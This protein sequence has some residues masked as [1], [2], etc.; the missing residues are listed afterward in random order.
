MPICLH[1]ARDTQWVLNIMD[2]REEPFRIPTEK[3]RQDSSLCSLSRIL[4]IGFQGARWL[5]E[6]SHPHP[7]PRCLAKH[8][9]WVLAERGREGLLGTSLSLWSSSLCCSVIPSSSGVNCLILVS[10][11]GDDPW[12]VSEWSGAVW[13]SGTLHVRLRKHPACSPLSLVRRRS[14]KCF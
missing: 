7:K 8:P 3:E 2:R 9:A 13:A 11:A 12:S 10:A 14:F 6:I 5:R 4:V 1:Q